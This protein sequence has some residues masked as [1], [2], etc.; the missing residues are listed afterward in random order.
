MTAVMTVDFNSI[1]TTSLMDSVVIPVL[2]REILEFLEPRTLWNAFQIA[3]LNGLSEMVGQI[4]NVKEGLRGACHGKHMK[5]VHLMIQ[6]G[7]D[8]WMEGMAS[9]CFAGN[10][11]ILKLMIEKGKIHKDSKFDL[12]PP[13]CSC[14][15]VAM[16]CC[17]SGTGS[18]EIIDLMIE[19][20]AH[21]WGLS[22]YQSCIGNNIKIAKLMIEKGAS[23]INQS[24][25]VA[26][27][28]N[29]IKI[30]KLLCSKKGLDIDRA[31]RVIS[32]NTHPEIVK[33]LHNV[34]NPVKNPDKNPDKKRQKT[35]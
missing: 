22:L 25:E 28:K 14:W 4:I 15:D 24:L 3:K 26:I 5:L 32:S 30:I 10:L 27:N 31:L 18:Q 12:I 2:T 23:N 1:K 19:K 33:Y 8:N 7:S 17:A 13:G 11:E 20:G 35:Q 29:H 21:E 9:A 34:K 6:K 16:A